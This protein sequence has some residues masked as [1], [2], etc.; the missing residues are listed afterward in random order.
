MSNSLKVYTTNYIVFGK[1]TLLGVKFSNK[2]VNYFYSFIIYD[3]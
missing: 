1:L 3:L 2:N